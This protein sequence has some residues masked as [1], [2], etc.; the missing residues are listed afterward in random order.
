MTELLYQLLKNITLKPRYKISKL[1]QELLCQAPAWTLLLNDTVVTPWIQ[2]TNEN[3]LPSLSSSHPTDHIAS[4]LFNCLSSP[5]D[6]KSEGR[7]PL[8]LLYMPSTLSSTWPSVG[9][10]IYF[11]TILIL[12]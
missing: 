7:E 8:P 11:C 12:K 6:A 2:Q 4:C 10:E 5:L 1:A 9:T 3:L